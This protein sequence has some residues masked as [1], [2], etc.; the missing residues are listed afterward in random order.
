M[1]RDEAGLRCSVEQRQGLD[2]I[3]LPLSTAEHYFHHA[4]IAR[5]SETVKEMAVKL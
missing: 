1:P 4:C 2:P 5:L 3:V